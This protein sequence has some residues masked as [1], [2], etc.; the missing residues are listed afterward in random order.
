VIVVFAPAPRPAGATEGLIR[1]HDDDA[2]LDLVCSERTVIPAGQF[3]DI[4]CGVAVQMPFNTWGLLTGRSSTLRKRG[5]LVAQGIIDPGYRGPL[6]S[7]V[8][9]LG[10]ES[11]V[12][13]AG[14]R[15]AQLIIIH[16]TAFQTVVRWI[17][18]D[19]ELAASARGVDGFGSSG[20]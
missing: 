12:V 11:H 4:P 19:R 9:N 15:I 18:P 8:W 10:P 16:N 1:T 2:G 7:G 20:R 6:F 13:E 3:R 5:L 14:E 17:G